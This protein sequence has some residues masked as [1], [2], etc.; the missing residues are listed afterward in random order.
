MS[1][2]HSGKRKQNTSKPTV[3]C[4]A[5][6][7]TLWAAAVRPGRMHDQ[8]AVK[9]EGIADPLAQH[10]TVKVRVDEG[11]RGPATAFPEQLTAPPRKPPK[12]AAAAVFR[13]SIKLRTNPCLPG[14]SPVTIIDNAS[15][16]G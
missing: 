2:G 13:R 4:D 15:R 9:T 1:L 11:Y 14:R 3:C 10:P 16:R 8:T 7:R 5:H 6:G 12:D